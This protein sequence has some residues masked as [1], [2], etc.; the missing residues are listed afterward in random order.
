[1]NFTMRRPDVPPVKS[2]NPQ[3]LCLK[4]NLR[5]TS[6]LNPI[7]PHSLSYYNSNPSANKLGRENDFCG[8]NFVASGKPLYHGNIHKSA[9][10]EKMVISSSKPSLKFQSVFEKKSKDRDSMQLKCREHSTGDL[11][12]CQKREHCVKLP[13][14]HLSNIEKTVVHEAPSPGHSKLNI[15]KSSVSSAPEN[16]CGLVGDLNRCS[17]SYSESDEDSWILH[18]RKA[19][20]NVTYVKHE[21]AT[22]K[23]CASIMEDAPCSFL[24]HRDNHQSPKRVKS[25]SDCPEDQISGP[26]DVGAADRSEGISE[27]S[28]LNSRL[29][30]KMS[31]DSVIALIGQELFW[32]TR[33]T[34]THQ[35]RIFAIQLFE[36]HR[37]TK[38]MMARSRD[39]F[40]KDNFYLHQPSIKFS[41]LKTLPCHDVLE[42]PVVALEQKI[43]PKP[44]NFELPVDNVNLPLRKD[45]DKK[46]IPQ[47]SA[48]KLNV[49]TPTS[50]SFVSDPKLAPRSFQPPPGYQWLVPIRSPSEGL[51]YKP[52]TGPCPPPGGIIAPAYG[53]CR[54]VTLSPPIGGDFANVPYNVPTSHKQGVGIFPGPVIF[55]P[56]CIQPYSMPVVKPSASSS[57][58]EQMNP[59]SRI[60]SSEKENSPFMHDANL[61]RPHQKSR[62]ISFQKSAV[63]SDCDR[64]IQADRGSDMQGSTASSPPERVQKDALALFPITP[65]AK[66][67]DQPVQ[68][69]D[70]EQQIQV[71]K[72]VPHNP[73][74]ASES[75]ARIFRSIQEERKMNY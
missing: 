65:T 69:N 57:A 24:P 27:A 56:S 66:G 22:T 55:D 36:L 41:S 9:D 52:Y 30:E 4:G 64:I 23:R 50:I 71:I 20:E 43:S 33:R 74:S 53:S 5:G 42:P 63:M 28:S 32:K 39:I 10:K 59:L 11:A 34:I 44:N 14:P 17:D 60:R 45:N 72:V 12:K 70:T 19:A 6:Q 16:R 38:K 2:L 54:P 46:N 47:Q 51:V 48:Q 40:F 75:A 7:Q 67:S 73:K 58:I 8:P 68:D 25:S 26:P 62:N 15:S 61:V 37:L 18:K 29:V 31:S 3:V 49:G 13:A 35:Q 1:M 21:D